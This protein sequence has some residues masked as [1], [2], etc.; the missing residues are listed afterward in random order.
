[1]LIWR[2][3]KVHA[4]SIKRAQTLTEA[5]RVE[6]FPGLEI[7][8]KNSSKKKGHHQTEADKTYMIGRDP[9]KK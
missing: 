3:A 2:N 9:D 6:V 7:L 4:A 1:M 5:E 8:K